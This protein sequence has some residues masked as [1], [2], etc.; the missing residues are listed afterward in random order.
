MPKWLYI[1]LSAVLEIAGRG[2]SVVYLPHL[3]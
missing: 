3:T 2:D 1:L